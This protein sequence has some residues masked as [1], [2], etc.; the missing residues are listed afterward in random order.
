[1]ARFIPPISS[2]AKKD[3]ILKNKSIRTWWQD[4]SVFTYKNALLAMP[5]FYDVDVYN[6]MKIPKDYFILLDSG[7]FELMSFKSRGKEL[8]ITQ[9]DVLEW[10]EKNGTAGIIL[11]HPPVRISGDGGHG[12][13]VPVDIN[14]FRQC[15]EETHKNAIYARDNRKNPDF[16]LYNVMQGGDLDRM[17]IWWDVVF[18]NGNLQF[19]GVAVAPKPPSKAFEVAKCLAFLYE[20]GIR[21]NVHVLGVSGKSVVPVIVYWSKYIENLTYD[22]A[23]YNQGRINSMLYL[24]Y[25]MDGE[26]ISRDKTTLKRMPCDCLVC[27]MFAIDEF[28]TD[29]T[30]YYLDTITLHNLRV[31]I[32]YNEILNKAIDDLPI[33]I[34]IAKQFNDNIEILIKYIEFCREHG[35]HKATKRFNTQNRFIE[36][37]NTMQKSVFHY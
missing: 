16:L 18:E 23:S 17:D 36:N 20:K 11:D 15:A 8:D 1:M 2:V 14:E 5:Y 33:F 29:S 12:T 6:G 7:G 10:Q 27:D 35:V 3:L 25:D 13:V 22:S 24:P 4:N 37:N 32:R 28:P 31:Y 9:K 21:K 26:I 30:S 19:E 34:R